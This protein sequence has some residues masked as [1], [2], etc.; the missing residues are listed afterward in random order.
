MPT[1]DLVTSSLSWL[2][3]QNTIMKTSCI[4]STRAIH[5]CD[6]I[7]QKVNLPIDK[8][9]PFDRLREIIFDLD[10]LA[11]LHFHFTSV[12]RCTPMTD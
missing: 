5:S 12:S 7:V 8:C 10:Q 1:F 3:I 4:M 6:F 11:N 9:N 2:P